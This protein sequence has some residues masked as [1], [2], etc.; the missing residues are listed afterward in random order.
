MKNKGP[1]ITPESFSRQQTRLY[2][3]V[4]TVIAMLALSLTQAQAQERSTS[5]PACILTKG[6]YTCDGVTFQKIL[7]NAKTISLETHTIDKVARSQLTEFITKKLN[8]TVVPEGSPC[9]LVFLL[10]PIE[11][12]GVNYTSGDAEL[13][14]LRIYLPNS[15]NNRGEIVW[16]EVFSGRIELPWPSVVHCVIT[17]FQ[18]TFHIK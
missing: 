15:E 6:V 11:A 8:K 10:L 9:D 18:S 7:A 3:L 16:A 5:T 17:Q 1:R 2:F 12:T 14:T 13:G 4:L